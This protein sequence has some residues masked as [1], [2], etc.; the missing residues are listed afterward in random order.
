MEALMERVRQNMNTGGVWHRS[1][2]EEYFIF[3]VGQSILKQKAFMSFA[4]HNT[5]GVKPLLGCYKGQAEQS[6]ISNYKDFLTIE[7]WLEAEESILHLGGCNSSNE[8]KATLVFLQTGI[9]T[10]LGRLR[11]VSRDYALSCDSWTYDQF[12]HTYYVCV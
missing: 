2:R 1:T 10:E 11:A 4:Y 3:C 8:P 6:F 5:I 12:T 7:P 9:K